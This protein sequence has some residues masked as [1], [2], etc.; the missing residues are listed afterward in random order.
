M[1]SNRA[2]KSGLAAE[3][4]AKMNSKYSEELAQEALEWIKTITEED[5]NTSG[6]AENFF[7][8]LKDG[9]LLCKLVNCLEANSVKKINT[10]KMAFKCMENITNFLT[11]ATKFG[12]NS[13]ELFQSVDLWERQNLSTVVT[14][15][16]SLGRKAQKFGKPSIGPVEATK[17]VRT[18]TEE[19][20]RAGDGII[21]LQYGS[22]QGAT[23]SGMNIGNSRHL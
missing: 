17:N 14:C 20:L 6:E 3:A 8:V 1:S 5:I 23:Q 19:Q 13:Q 9:V 4:Q 12:V 15:L 22:N 2:E 21:S 7:E 11:S 16:Q 10:S 18:F